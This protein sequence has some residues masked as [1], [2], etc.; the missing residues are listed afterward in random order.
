MVKYLWLYWAVNLNFLPYTKEG[1]QTVLYWTVQLSGNEAFKRTD[2]WCKALDCINSHT[3][4]PT[5]KQKCL[6]THSGAHAMV[7]ET[8]ILFLSSLTFGPSL[9]TECAFTEMSPQCFEFP[10]YWL[11]FFTL[12]SFLFTLVFLGK[13]CRTSPTV[14]LCVCLSKCACVCGCFFSWNNT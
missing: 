7:F 4:Q 5:H 8:L 6:F 14:C 12:L 9:G 2:V 3:L 10:L 11:C 1:T 13:V